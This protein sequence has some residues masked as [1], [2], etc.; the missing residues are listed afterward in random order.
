M[1]G[2]YNI[3]IFHWRPTNASIKLAKEW[4]DMLFVDENIWDQHGFNELTHKSMGPSVD[5]ESGIFY[6]FDGT[7]KLG[8][9]PASIFCS[10]HTFF[11]QVMIF[12]INRQG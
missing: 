1:S 5:E 10:G 6:A 11:V 7:L 9:L 4:K 2:A 8:I 12:L 3:G